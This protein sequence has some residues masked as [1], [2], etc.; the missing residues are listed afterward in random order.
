MWKYVLFDLPFLIFVKDGFND[1]QLEAW[2]QAVQSG[3]P[4]PPYSRYAPAPNKPAAFILGG[5]SPVYLPPRP[6]AEPYLVAVADIM[7]GIRF[8]RRIN[9]H[10]EMVLA[11]EVPGDRTGRASYSTVQVVFDLRSVRS[12]LHQDMA[13]FAT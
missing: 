12:E 13:L 7:V 11:G 10:R 8:L 6:L 5:G 4:N 2:V 1:P 9:P 3:V